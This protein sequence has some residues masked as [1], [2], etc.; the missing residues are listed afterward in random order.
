MLLKHKL[1]L[2]RSEYAKKVK[3]EAEAVFGSNKGIA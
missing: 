1:H 3:E 2:A